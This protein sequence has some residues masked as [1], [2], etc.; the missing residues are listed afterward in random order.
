MTIW[1]LAYYIGVGD[2]PL[3]MSRFLYEQLYLGK[4]VDNVPIVALPPIESYIK[5]Y[6]SAVA[7]FFASSD[8]CGTQG[9]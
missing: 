1:S 3:C 9:F 7:M 2:L 8:Y 5:V 6:P 4:D